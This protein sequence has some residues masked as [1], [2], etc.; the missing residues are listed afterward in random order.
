M[1]KVISVSNQ[2][3]GVGKTTTTLALSEGFRQRGHR[4]LAID[5]DPQ[6]NL[7]FSMG[8]ESEMSATIYDVLKG[9]AKS[10][11]AIQ[12]TPRGDVIASN[13]LLSGM[14]LEFTNAGREFLLRNAIAPLAEYYDYIFI[15]TPPALSILTVNAFAASDCII[16]P[17]LSDI[18]SLQG[19]AQLHETVEKVR[20]HCNSDLRIGGILLTRFNPRFLL[21]NEIRGTAEMISRDLN[22]PLLDTFI[23]T[24][25]VFSEAQSMQRGAIEYAPA[26][27]AVQDY[28]NLVDELI[29][30][31]I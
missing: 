28:I 2:K 16:V 21:S 12:R 5:L 31:G 29:E 13:I 9:D 17:V 10:K 22:I 19:L 7:S 4:V 14:E 6:G 25:V 3:G 26:N 20:Q 24:S 15:D 18:F 23:R 27:N 8:A 30:R 1:C 11:F